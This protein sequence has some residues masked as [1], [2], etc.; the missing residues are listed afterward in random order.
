MVLKE[1]L[2][3]REL[4]QQA[5]S[6]HRKNQI[7]A[8]E[9]IYREIFTSNLGKT[10]SDLRFFGEVKSSYA[11]LLGSLTKGIYPNSAMLVGVVGALKNF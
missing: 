3:C 1:S 11:Q 2:R 9:K 10:L 8:A 7:D 4:Y 6:L 5:I